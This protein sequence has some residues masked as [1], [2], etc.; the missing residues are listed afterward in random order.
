MLVRT[1]A[2]SPPHTINI[3]PIPLV[4]VAAATLAEAYDLIQFGRAASSETEESHSS[5]ESS[6]ESRTTE[7]AMVSE[8]VSSESA[9]DALFNRQLPSF[10]QAHA[11]PAVDS[12]TTDAIL[13]NATCAV[14][15]LAESVVG[16][17]CSKGQLETLRAC[18]RCTKAKTACTHERPCGRCARLGEV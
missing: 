6:G 16:G 15:V 14:G 13:E 5:E 3:Q 4:E 1:V 18:A 9:K 8:R 11:M 17:V 10:L 2:P 7:P 12:E